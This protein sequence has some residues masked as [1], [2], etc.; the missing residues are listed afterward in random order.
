M[1][2]CAKDDSWCI[3]GSHTFQFRGIHQATTW[4]WKC[5]FCIVGCLGVPDE[6][7]VRF[8]FGDISG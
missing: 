3:L 2:L 4:L 6:S 8:V 5:I 7:S 1:I